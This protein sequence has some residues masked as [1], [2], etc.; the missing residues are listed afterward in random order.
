MFWHF[1]VIEPTAA[2]APESTLSPLDN[3]EEE[4]CKEEEEEEEEGEE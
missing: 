1:P 3:D 2:A 4:K